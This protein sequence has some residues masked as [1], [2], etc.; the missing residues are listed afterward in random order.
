MAEQTELWHWLISA[1]EIN[2]SVALLIV[3]DSRGSSP[4]TP[5]AKMAVSLQNVIGT[6]GGGSIES[7]MIASARAMLIK[8]ESHPKVL[9]RAH[10]ASADLK[11]SGM[12]CGGEQ[13]VLIYPCRSTDKSSFERLISS[14]E[15]GEYSLFKVS[16]HGVQTSPQITSVPVPVTFESGESWQYCECL[17]PRKRAFIVGGGHIALALSKI[18]EMLDFDITV[19]DEREGLETMQA[20]VYAKQKWRLPYSAIARAVPEGNDVFAFVMTHDHRCDQEVLTELAGKQLAYLGLLG[21]RHKI[22]RIRQ[23]LT[24][25]FPESL[26]QSIHAP[27]GLPIGSHT[28]EEIAVSIAAEL[29]QLLNRKPSI[30]A[31]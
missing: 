2:E 25:H 14:V 9:R 16:A 11:P 26:C 8:G 29:V 4:G 7:E 24:E 20:N 3:A 6:V 22:S 28:P 23:T 30:N 21:S 19:I 12:I 10:R 13:T 31:C 1:L 27:M 18:L 17:G 15:K 5:G